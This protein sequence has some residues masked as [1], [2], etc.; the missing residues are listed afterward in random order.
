MARIGMRLCPDELKDVTKR[1]AVLKREGKHELD[2][3]LR[4]IVFVGQGS[5]M[6]A[7]ARICEVGTTSVK[8]WA[9]IYRM[10]GEWVLISKGT[11]NGKK[12]RL[13]PDGTL[14]VQHTHKFVSLRKSLN[15]GDLQAGLRGPESRFL[16]AL[17]V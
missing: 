2:R 7:T 13:S 1:R 12:P 8:G 9:D 16:T 11:Y 10:H 4:V 15:R 5:T 3:R 6:A 17:S 14:S